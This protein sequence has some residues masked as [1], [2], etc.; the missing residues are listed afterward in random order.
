MKNILKYASLLAAAV[1]LLSCGEKENAGG[2]LV[3]T[4]DRNLIGINEEAVITVTLGDKV[5]T[6]GV[7]FYDSDMKVLDLP[8]FRFSADK[9]GKY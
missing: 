2:K 6:D 9:A 1:M 3:L 8:D 4:S 5:I 7:V